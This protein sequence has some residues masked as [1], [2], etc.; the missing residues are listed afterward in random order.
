MR[1]AATHTA[2]TWPCLPGCINGFDHYAASSPD[3]ACAVQIGGTL[4]G[5]PSPLSVE[6]RRDIDTGEAWVEFAG[7]RPPTFALSYIDAMALSASLRDAVEQLR[8]G[9][10]PR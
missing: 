2:G 9:G 1:D 5:D 7:E 8:N 3:R 10:E 4:F 6:A